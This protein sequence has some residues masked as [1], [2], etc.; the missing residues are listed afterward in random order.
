VLIIMTDQP[1]WDYMTAAGK[2]PVPTP[3]IDRIASHGVRFSSAVCP[4]PVCA[5]SRMARLSGLYAHTSGV[6]NND[7]LLPWNTPTM[8]NS[9][10]DRG[11]HTGLIGKS[12]VNDGHTHGFQYFLGFNDWFMYL[13]PNVQAYANAVANDFSTKFFKT[14]NDDGSGLPE[15]PSVWGK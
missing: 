13:G 4:Y 8:A 3:N 6:I 15:L 11:Y 5:A 12:H 14:V 10:A 1:R 2:L 7:N 9:F